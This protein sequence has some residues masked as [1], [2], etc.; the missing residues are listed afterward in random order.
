[1]RNVQFLLRNEIKGKVGFNTAGDH[2]PSVSA[3]G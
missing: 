2:A 3:E 1:M